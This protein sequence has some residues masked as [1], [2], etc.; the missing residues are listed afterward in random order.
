MKKSLRGVIDPLTL[1]V[2]AAAIIGVSMLLG[3]KPLNVFKKKPPT[4]ELTKLQA[5]L[6]AA[7]AAEAKAKT[8]KDAA[9]AAERQ[10]FTDALRSAQQANE[11]GAYL[12]GKIP[13]EHQT[14][15]SKVGTA[16]VLRA[17]FR[18]AA[19]LG[20]LPDDVLK[21]VTDMMDGLIA[22]RDEALAKLAESDHKFTELTGEHA[23][24]V[25]QL[26]DATKLAQATAEK[27]G[28]V[29]VKVTQVTNEVKQKADALDAEMRKSGSLDA[30]VVKLL[31]A[32]GII[33]GAWFFFAFVVPGIVKHMASGNPLKTGLR[34]LSGYALNPLLFHDAKKKLTALTKT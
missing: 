33:A 19:M 1:S 14:P 24:T 9:V 18:L 10:K 2:V 31:W 8:E 26:A 6:A 22:E 29:Q 5:D 17:N 12:L 3:F 28:A 13:A 27:A 30:V 16:M 25:K 7:Q 15:Q 20:K 34:N 21:D 23:A 32:G 4:V 11:G